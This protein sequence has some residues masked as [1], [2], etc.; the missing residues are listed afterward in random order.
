AAAD[1]RASVPVVD[2][3]PARQLAAGGYHTC[4]LVDGDAVW[5]WGTQAG[6]PL[7]RL[8]DGAPRPAP[9]TL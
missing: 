4:A 6:A 9:V 2:L 8:Q 3:P 1:R 5:C 7:H